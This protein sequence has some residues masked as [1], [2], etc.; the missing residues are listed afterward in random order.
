MIDSDRGQERMQKVSAYIDI[1]KEH[2]LDPIKLAIAWCLLN[3]NVSTVILGA[4]NENQLEKNLSSIDYI[5]KFED[6]EL[7]NNLN[8]L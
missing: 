5:D 4:S 8:N 6:Q 1:A 2:N 7:I 3:K